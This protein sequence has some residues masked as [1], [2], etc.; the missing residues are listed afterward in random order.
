[1]NDTP[2]SKLYQPGLKKSSL[3]SEIEPENRVQSPSTSPTGQESRGKSK[4]QTAKKRRWLIP[5]GVTLVLMGVGGFYI[6]SQRPD[7]SAFLTKQTVPVRNQN[8]TIR[9][10][11]SGT[12]VP[13]ATVNISPKNAGRLAAL[14]VD[15]GT[16]VKAGQLIARMDDAYLQAELAQAKAELAQAVADYTKM[17]VGNRREAIARARSQ[18]VSTQA[19]AD[20]TQERVKRYRN[21]AAEGA[22]T[23]DD[24]DSKISDDRSAQASL[25]EAQQQFQEQA[26]GSRV[27]DI[28]ASAQKVEAARAKVAQAKADQA[29]AES[30]FANQRSQARYDV[31]NAFLSL[32]SQREQVAESQVGVDSAQ[33]GLRLARLRLQ[34]GVGTQTDVVQSQRDLTNA[35]SNLSQAIIGYNRAL[36]Q[37]QRSVTRL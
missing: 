25:Q 1:M 10:E 19:K 34:A 3:Y 24:L 12:V 23:K 15:Q 20:L 21:L 37:L 32:Q 9:I 13:I 7:P 17:R 27:E 6:V 18:V 29:V 36:V 28:N 8:Q 11:A 4:R 5:L 35:Q 16:R 22:V 30:E 26:T 14:Y 33:E 31:E 2:D